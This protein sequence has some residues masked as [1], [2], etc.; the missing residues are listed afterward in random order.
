[1]KI[2]VTGSHGLIGSALVTR[3]EA[4]GHYVTRLHRWPYSAPDIEGMDAVIHLAGASIAGRWTEARKRDIRE[5]RIL[6]TRSLAKAIAETQRPPAVFISASAIGYYGHRHSETMQE[7]HDQGEGF[8]AGVCDGWEKA[9]LPA[10]RAHVRVVNLRFGV[11]LSAQGGALAAMLTPFRLGLGGRIGCGRQYMSWI[12]L[13]DAVGIIQRALVSKTL[14]GPVN[15]VAPYP[16]TNIEFTETLARTLHRRARFPMPAL[17]ARLVFGEMA[18]ELLLA[19]T[20]VEPIRL[21]ATGYRFQY[22]LLE[23]ALRHLLESP[24]P[25]LAEVHA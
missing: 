5:S 3:L 21:I 9:A 22:P 10:R 25:A 20:R 11:V 19:S 24:A 7:E 17:V 6:G 15:A 16:V 8:L 4:A 1:M 12:A 23:G 13:E 14:D 18:E 2:A